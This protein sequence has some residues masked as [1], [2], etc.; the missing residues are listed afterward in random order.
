MT[1]AVSAIVVFAC[2]AGYAALHSWLASLSVKRATR[3]LIGPVA[4]RFYRLAFNILGAVTLLPL[5]AFTAWQPGLVLYRVPPPFLW[6]CLAGQ[7]AAVM[8]VAV[9]VLQTDA[10]HFLGVRQLMEP[11]VAS[12]RLEIGGLY[13]Y[14][15]HPLYSAA[16]VFLWLTPLM[17]TTLFAMYLGF[18][19]YLFIGSLFE[20]RRLIQEFGASYR[21]Y[22]RQVPR[23]VPRWPRRRAAASGSDGPPA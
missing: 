2:T 9:G 8:M 16:L 20:E 19:L 5:L 23:L 6:L 15:R 10:W 1:P 14:V 22:Q 3:R 13:R 11:G 18:S 12:P 7:A 17:T 21:A 4:D